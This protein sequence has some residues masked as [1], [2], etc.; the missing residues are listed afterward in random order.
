MN[1]TK[2][3]SLMY[4]ADGITPAGTSFS[5]IRDRIQDAL[6]AAIMG[7]A[8]MD[9][10][11]DNDS[12]MC[13]D[14]GCGCSPC[15]C[16]TRTYAWVMDVFP[17]TFVYSMDGEMFQCPYTD[18]GDTVTLG[19]P[20]EVET[21]Y[22]TVASDESHRRVLAAECVQLT[23]SFNKEAGTIPLTVIKP[24]FN[25]SKQRYYPAATLKRDYKIFEGARM[26]ADHQTEREATERP[27]GS[28]HTWVGTIKKVWAEGDGTVKAQAAIIDPAFRA[29]LEMLNSQKMIS[30]M[31][32]SIRAIGEASTQEVE[33]LETTYIESLLAA[34]S[35]DFVTYAG[36]GGQVDAIESAVADPNDVDIITETVLRKRRPDLIELIETKFQGEQM[37]TAEQQL[38][39]ANTQ[40][41]DTKKKL[42]EATKRIEESEKVAKK[43]SAA[44]ELTK[45]LSESK[46]PKV[47][48][49][50][51]KKVY[52]EAV[53]TDGMKE[54]I[55]A[56]QEY[57]KT[58]NVEITKH[59][60]AEEN[61][62]TEV[63]ESAEQ[64]SKKKSATAV[65][66]FMAMG[67]TEA[68]AKIAAAGKRC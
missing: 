31:G 34:R 10:D 21:S 9:L 18:D 19:T 33:G 20:Y 16:G 63:Q 59:N 54:A 2:E 7:G 43:A 25:K 57:L 56:E 11:G 51:L 53:S 37:K 24:G 3:V 67:F 48:Q 47:S 1:R 55:T 65:E 29:K 6:Q 40:L 30:D 26:F 45:M 44:A 62:S 4:E 23:E 52:A 13:V 12:G 68:E 61:G 64:P 36:A 42:E 15:G 60:G 39:E 38:G 28:V 50:R 8:D 66:A 58:L 22:T 49:E 14:G 5:A 17:S 41:A 27:E 32:V 35:V 46:L